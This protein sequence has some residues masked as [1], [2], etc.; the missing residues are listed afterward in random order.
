MHA[1]CR[2]T[3]TAAA[4]LIMLSL[5]IDQ[6]Q[7]VDFGLTLTCNLFSQTHYLQSTNCY[8]DDRVLLIKNLFISIPFYSVAVI[9]VTPIRSDFRSTLCVHFIVQGNVY[10]DIGIR[11]VGD[12]MIMVIFIT[13]LGLAEQ[14]LQLDA[15]NKTEEGCIT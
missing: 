14:M 2:T 7:L 5:A 9:V 3:Y 13:P 8:Y 11:C 15:C 6:K 10:V 1:N 12:M 4:N